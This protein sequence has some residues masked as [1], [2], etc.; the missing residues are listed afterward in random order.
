[1]VF[2]GGRARIY[3]TYHVS[4]TIRLPAPTALTSLNAHHT[5]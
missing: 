5:N 4:K 3:V 2:K 1:M